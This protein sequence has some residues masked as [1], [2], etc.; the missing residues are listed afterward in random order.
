MQKEDD[1]PA[2]VEFELVDV[3]PIED[4]RSKWSKYIHIDLSLEAV[5]ENLIREIQDSAETFALEPEDLDDY[6]YSTCFMVFHIR[7]K[8]HRYHTLVS[9]KYVLTAEQEFINELQEALGE[10]QV[11]FSDRITVK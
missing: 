11:W 5:S 7:T 1:P 4:A 2:P 6:Q 10:E 3:M 9:K 8:T